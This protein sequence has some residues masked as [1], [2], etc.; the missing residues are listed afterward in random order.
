MINLKNEIGEE[1]YEAFRG[2]L[3]ATFKDERCSI[4]DSLMGRV[5]CAL[6]EDAQKALGVV[7]TVFDTV[8]DV[9]DSIIYS[10]D[11]EVRS[12][13]EIAATH[14]RTLGAGRHRFEARV[15]FVRIS[16]PQT[17]KRDINTRI[18]TCFAGD[19]LTHTV[20]LVRQKYQALVPFVIDRVELITPA[21]Y[22]GAR[23][24]AVSVYLLYS[25]EDTVEGYLLEAGMATG[26]PLVQFL[27]T[28]RDTVISRP[29]WYEPTPFSK[30]SQWYRGEARFYGTDDLDRVW[31]D[32]RDSELAPNHVRVEA[33]F[34]KL[35][36][37]PDPVWPSKLTAQAAMRVAAIADAMGR[38]DTMMKILAPFGRALEWEEEPQK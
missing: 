26:E 22:Y 34:M 16:L 27:G 4:D 17:Q 20:E 8:H 12:Y 24:A 38:A 11:P 7:G 32:V 2:L 14:E 5:F 13:Y 23:F 3:R 28:H 31:V 15:P 19:R 37:T 25:P 35:D 18:G 21:R 36:H 29:S 1:K 33:H 10:S 9:A 30:P 6:P